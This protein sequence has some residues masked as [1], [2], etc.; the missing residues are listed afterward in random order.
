[1]K[2]FIFIICLCFLCI[3]CSKDNSEGSFVNNVMPNTI[4]KGIQ[5]TLIQ[6]NEQEL[7]TFIEGNYI[8]LVGNQFQITINEDEAQNL[9]FSKA[10]YSIMLDEITDANNIL[11]DI[12]LNLQQDSKIKNI[13]VEYESVNNEISNFVAV[14]TRSETP[15]TSGL[16]E[17]FGAEPDSN[18]GWA[19]FGAKKVS[20]FCYAKVSLI[21]M[22]FVTTKALGNAIVTSRMGQG[23]L[24][25]TLDASNTY[26]TITYRTSDSFGGK[27]SWSCY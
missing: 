12:I 15:K 14:K 4:N 1:M 8:Q 10:T 16:I 27:C 23:S 6:S 25:A 26:F 24:D 3:A 22:H 13:Y 5:D 17:T 11:N 9:G 2:N 18:Q 7:Q 20:C 19:P 21:A